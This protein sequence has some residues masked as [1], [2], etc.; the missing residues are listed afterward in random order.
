MPGPR[1][2]AAPRP[3]SA[4]SASCRPQGEMCVWA[5][6]F[7]M[8]GPTVWR[9][10]PWTIASPL[11]TF[12]LLRFLSGGG[13]AGAAAGGAAMCKVLWGTWSASRSAWVGPALQCVRPGRTLPRW[14]WC[15]Q[16][17]PFPFP[18]IGPIAPPPR[19]FAPGRDCLPRRS[20]LRCKLW[21]APRPACR[22]PAPG[23]AVPREVRRAACLRGLCGKHQH[24]APLA[25]T[26]QVPLSQGVNGAW[27]GVYTG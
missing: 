8:A 23:A 17:T 16:S 14:L 10:C 21:A 3:P 1:G 27:P 9:R 22:H 2:E 6:V 12:A 13:Q 4:R 26:G 5:G 24:A 11:F 20:A 15:Y 25:T 18:G 19:S 7:V